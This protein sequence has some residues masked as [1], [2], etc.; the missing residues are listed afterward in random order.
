MVNFNFKMKHFVG[1]MLIA[2][3][4][5]EGFSQ[6]KKLFVPQWI[7]PESPESIAPSIMMAPFVNV[8]VNY[9]TAEQNY[10]FF[11]AGANYGNFIW[12]MNMH[13]TTADTSWRYAIVSF[14]SIIHTPTLTGYSPGSF[15]TLQIDSIQITGGHENNSFA[16]DTLVAKIIG[17]DAGG[18]PGNTVYWEDTLIFNT[19]QSI[20]NNWLNTFQFKFYPD[21]LL[22]IT[23]F[24]VKIE[25]WGS[26]LDTFGLLAGYG[27][28]TG[29]CG[30]DPVFKMAQN[31]FYSPINTVAG[32]RANTFAYWTQFNN[33][34]P[35]NTG[36][37]LYY[38]CNG[39]GGQQATGDGSNYL[40]NLNVTAYLTLDLG[41][42]V[43]AGVD[44]VICEGKQ[45]TLSG[46]V[47]GGT[48]PFSYQWDPPIG[49]SCV[50]CPV[51]LA[52]PSLT[53]IYTLIVTGATTSDTDTVVVQ[54]DPNNVQAD[55]SV[56]QTDL[57]AVFTNLS[58]NAS[59][60]L[61]NFGAGATPATST[62]SGP[63]AVM[64]AGT[65]TKT[66]SLVATQGSNLCQDTVAKEI[67]I[68][69]TYIGSREINQRKNWKI[70]PN[71][72]D[73]EFFLSYL[74]SELQNFSYKVEDLSGRILQQGTFEVSSAQSQFSI[75]LPEIEPGIYQ[76]S[77]YGKSGEVYIPMI[78]LR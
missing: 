32:F 1:I 61:W 27:Y 78:V 6:N 24:A 41:M 75:R 11:T 44:A 16:M 15:S 12:P 20:L 35:T 64:Y 17:L 26:E 71:P 7:A 33:Q 38:E 63:I 28:F 77:V 18:Y 65:G 43:N 36:A 73:G 9:N 72:N 58:A 14:D 37:N 59:N 23:G 66:V 56:V 13:N 51:T 40:Q 62:F 10:W 52:S 39:L 68:T 30:T 46:S 53:T 50:T 42:N 57:Q 3:I 2:F 29:L 74:G 48:G 47:A 21:T 31:T 22:P 4:I 54:V 34:Y 5:G 19:G 45:A 60:Y 8:Q 55:F 49:L 69:K 76:V 70:F 67:E 25:Y